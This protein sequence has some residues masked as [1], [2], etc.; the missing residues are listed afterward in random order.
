MV[1]ARGLIDCEEAI[2]L[3]L[4]AVASDGKNHFLSPAA[5]QAWRLLHNAATA[6]GVELFIVSAFRSVERQAEIVRRKLAA[7][8][9]IEDILA[10]C[11][12][13]GFSEHHSGRAVDVSTPGAAPL[14]PEF[15]QTAAFAWLKQR[16]GAF[17]F[18]LSFPAGNS[19][20]YCYEPW[21]WC[22]DDLHDRAT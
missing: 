20:G 22:F 5:A 3:E 15:D 7:G 2:D 11:A 18:H 8:Q 4:L 19:Q 13:P 10:V 21:H 17:G 14:E 16:A 1:D 6:D 12:P 9:A